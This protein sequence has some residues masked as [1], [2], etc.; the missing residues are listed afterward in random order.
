MSLPTTLQLDNNIDIGTLNM[1]ITSAVNSY[2]IE[3]A[4]VSISYTGVPQNTFEQLTTN[5]I[6]Q[7]DSIELAAPPLEYSLDATSNQQ[8]YSEYTLEINPPEFNSIKSYF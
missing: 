1:Q 3:G 4:T 8:P 6:G 7:T 5:N 2:P